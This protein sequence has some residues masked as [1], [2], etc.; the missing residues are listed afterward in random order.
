MPFFYQ[1]CLI[2]EVKEYIKPCESTACHDIYLAYFHSNECCRFLSNDTTLSGVLNSLDHKIAGKFSEDEWTERLYKCLVSQGIDAE[3]TA[4]YRG[5]QVSETWKDR[6]PE[7]VPK[8]C[9]VFRGSPDMIIKV[10]KDEGIVDMASDDKANDDSSDECTSSQ[11]SG[12]FQMG[13]QMTSG[14]R[15]NSFYDKVGELIAAVHTSLVCRALRKYVKR[16]KVSA[17]TSHGLHIHRSFG[18]ICLEVTL[19]DSPLKI[20]AR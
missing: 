13:H 11:E 8:G 9:L 7:A 2:D 6:L 18:V 10:N 14:Y 19:S 16:K 15:P 5:N 20:K 12:R 3:C 1:F 17:H 4:H